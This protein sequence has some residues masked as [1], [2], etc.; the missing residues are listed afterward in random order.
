MWI[1]SRVPPNPYTIRNLISSDP[2]SFL[3]TFHNKKRHDTFPNAVY[4]KNLTAN[5]NINININTGCASASG[6]FHYFLHFRS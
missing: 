5:I 2:Q 3:V 4:Q 1:S 6:Y